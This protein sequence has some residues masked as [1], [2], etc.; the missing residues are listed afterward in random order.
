MRIRSE[1]VPRATPG[2]SC[3]GQI[4]E[5]ET[6]RCVAQHQKNK[7]GNSRA[8]VCNHAKVI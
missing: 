6:R 2:V 8:K 3:C 5:Q 7:W 4:Y 1:E